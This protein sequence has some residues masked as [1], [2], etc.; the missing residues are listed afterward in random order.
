MRKKRYIFFGGYIVLLDGK[1][2]LGYNRI[3][4]VCNRRLRQTMGGLARPIK[5]E[6]F[7]FLDQTDIVI[8]AG[9]GGNGAVSFR[10]EMYVPAGGPDGGDG[11]NGGDVV[12]VIDAAVNTLADFRYKRRYF[13]E[14][15]EDGRGCR[16]KGKNGKDMV[17]AVPEGTIVRDAESGK[18]LADMTG[19][20]ARAVIERGGKGGFGN[21]HFATPVR[22]APQFAKSGIKKRERL[23]T[24]ELKMIADVGLIG[25]PNVGKSTLLSRV[26]AARP[27]IGNYHFTT[28]TPQPG[29]VSLGEGRSFVMADIP[30]LIKG[31][32]QG[33]GLGHDFLRHI[34]RT[35][36]LLHVVDI[37]GSEGRDPLCDFLD[38]NRELSL[39][40]TSLD[41][42]PQV[43]AANKSDVVLSEDEEK[44]KAAFYAY[45]KDKSVPFFEISAA[46]GEGLMA[47]LQYIEG[48]LKTLPALPTYEAELCYD[49]AQ[50]A[51]ADFTVTK[52]G[53]VFVV[54]G[55]F[56]ERLLGSVNLDNDESAAYF[57]RMLRRSG[58]IDALLDAG[59][60]E[61]D[62]VRIGGFE[63]DYMN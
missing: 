55:P 17:I 52:D 37:S 47:L 46:T 39:Y 61:G 16:C 35:R 24:L 36:L 18:I 38:I 56:A 2:F 12:F 13:A 1:A 49:D 3:D 21:Q 59:V 5:K 51:G 14:N 41:A 50:E 20:H 19:E 6:T 57:Q 40:K 26:S 31:A 42:L 4:I 28:L 45:L 7:M 62:T 44:Q 23:I 34:E 30:G 54:D 22:Q 10:R 48:R 8:K 11:G 32:S 60:R 25:F 29:V 58:V 9:D 33:A 27:N 15:G 43:V 53:A 63:F